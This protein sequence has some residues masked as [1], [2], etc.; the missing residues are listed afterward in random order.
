M[1]VLVDVMNG[2]PC[3]KISEVY[4]LVLA[5]LTTASAAAP[6]I[7]CFLLSLA[8]LVE[9]LCGLDGFGSLT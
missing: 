1:Q 6:S 4:V 7:A 8:V 3:P 2:C 9:G 5:V